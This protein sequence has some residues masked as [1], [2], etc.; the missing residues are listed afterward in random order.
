[1]RL[2]WTGS[3]S[4]PLLLNSDNDR[5]CISN[6]CLEQPLGHQ[7]VTAKQVQY[8]KRLQLLKCVCMSHHSVY[9]LWRLDIVHI[10][11]LFLKAAPYR[12]ACVLMLIFNLKTFLIILLY[13]KDWHAYTGLCAHTQ[14]LKWFE[15]IWRTDS[16]SN[17]KLECAYMIKISLIHSLIHSFTHSSCSFSS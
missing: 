12:V 5:V 13:N 14:T 17:A 15:N 1:M 16:I 4:K 7:Q 9:P 2:S 6:S 8:P 3:Q 10:H 11:N